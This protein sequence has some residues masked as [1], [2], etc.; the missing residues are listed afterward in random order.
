MRFFIFISVISSAFLSAGECNKKPSDAQKMKGRLE[1]AG[2]CMNYTISVLEGN[3][4]TDAVVTRWTDEMTNKIYSN[5]F[6]LG[7]PC[8]FPPTIKQG[9][10]FYFTIDTVK[11][12]P[13]AVCMAY[14]PTPAKALFIKVVE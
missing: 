11:D 4:G 1:V 6:K 3:P 9:D 8:D 2:I 5:V 12:K 14:Y 13:C 7:N 10:E